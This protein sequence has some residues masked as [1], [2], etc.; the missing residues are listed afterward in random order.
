MKFLIYIFI[1]LFYNMSKLTKAVFDGNY[2]L[3]GELYIIDLNTRNLLGI[4]ELELK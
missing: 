3:S 1:F 4:K 2:I